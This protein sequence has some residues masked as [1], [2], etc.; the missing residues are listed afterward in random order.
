MP[1]RHSTN[2]AARRSSQVRD[3]SC[4]LSGIRT[5][6]SGLAR[7]A[8]TDERLDNL[9]DADFLVTFYDAD[10]TIETELTVRVK[11]FV[12]MFDERADGERMPSPDRR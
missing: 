10:V 5:L 9:P 1:A 2:D 3:R 4:R 11:P 7:Y 12:C 6:A 8:R